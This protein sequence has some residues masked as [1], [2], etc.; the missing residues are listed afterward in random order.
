MTTTTS[1]HGVARFLDLMVQL[2]L[3]DDTNVT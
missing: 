3:V 1:L 2:R